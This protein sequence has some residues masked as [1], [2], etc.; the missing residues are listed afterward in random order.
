MEH[1]LVVDDH[2][3]VRVMVKKLIKEIPFTGVIHEAGSY[4]QAQE[5]LRIHPMKMVILDLSIPEGRDAEMIRGIREIQVE[6]PILILSGRD[7]RV[8][9]PFY[10]NKGANGFVSKMSEESEISLAI[11]TV[12]NGHRFLRKEIKNLILS[13]IVENNQMMFNPIHHLTVREKEIMQLLLKGISVKETAARLDLKMSTVSTH[14][15]R[16]CEKLN[17]ENIM[18]LAKKVEVYENELMITSPMLTD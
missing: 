15:L 1:I 16:I 8:H 10:M 18:E 9:A 6:V 3:L 17:V 13:S 11:L 14:K 12:L 4:S 5:M 2:P 7:E